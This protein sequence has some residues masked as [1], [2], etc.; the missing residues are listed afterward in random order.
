VPTIN[1]ARP[2]ITWLQVV[3]HILGWLPLAWIIYKYFSGGLSI[4]PVQDIE[5]RLGRI[6]VYFLVASLTCTPLSNIFGWRE[7]LKR[8]R[9][10]GLYAFMYISLHVLVFVGLDYGF[11][12]SQVVVLILGKL[13]LIFGTLAGLLLVPLALTS[14]DYFIRRMGKNWKRLHWLVYPAAFLSVLH[15]ALA[16]KGDLFALRGNILKPFLL[17]ISLIL[18]MVLRIPSVRRWISSLRSK[19][20]ARSRHLPAAHKITP[21]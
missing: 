8:R 18:L 2:R 4:N 10:M 19:F 13:Y 11:Y 16:Q 9:A 5:Q 17:G 15:Y 14:F 20:S 7:F 3:I 21:G 6:A 12:L 1:K